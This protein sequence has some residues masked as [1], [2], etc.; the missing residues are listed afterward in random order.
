MSKETQILRVLNSRQ[1]SLETKVLRMLEQ[2]ERM[3]VLRAE[4]AE[5]RR[6]EAEL[7]RRG[8]I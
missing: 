4:I 6:R 8:K 5:E 7:R 3:R 1:W 2:R